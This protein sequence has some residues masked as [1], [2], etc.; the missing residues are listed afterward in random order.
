MAKTSSRPAL[1]H[2]S[3]SSSTI[4]LTP[5][6][7]TRAEM[8]ELK[9]RRAS[10]RATIKRNYGAQLDYLGS[11]VVDQ[12]RKRDKMLQEFKH[13]TN[14]EYFTVIGQKPLMRRRW[15]LWF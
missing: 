6:R 14:F 9:A 8:T 13:L 1:R 10:R 5:P 4:A 11:Y 7:R 15:N 3:P 12:R 2:L